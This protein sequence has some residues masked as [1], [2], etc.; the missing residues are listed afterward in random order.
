[1]SRA[2]RRPSRLRGRSYALGAQLDTFLVCAASGVIVNHAFLIVTGSPQI[3]SRNPGAVHISHSIYGG[4][5][6]MVAIVLTLAYLA[7]AVRWVLA[8]VGGVG[9]GWWVDELGK[10]VSNAGYLFEPALALIYVTFVVMYLAF[11]SLSIRELGPEDALVNALATAK[12]AAL[13]SLQDP[14]RREILA[15]FDAAAPSGPF[16][17][18]VR[19]LL[20]DAPASPPLPPGRVR[21][22]RQRIRARY[23]AWTR[24]R[25]FVIVIDAVFVA[26]AAAILGGVLGLSLDGPGI[27]ACSERV[28]SV[29][30]T[31]A[32]ILTVSGVVRLL[33]SRLAA[34]RWFER[35]VFVR[36]L[37]VQVYLFAQEQFTAVVGLGVDLVLWVMLR[38]AIRVEEEAGQE[39][40]HRAPAGAADEAG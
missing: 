40:A 38:S 34:D 26:I 17:D 21:R 33:R 18:R 2:G 28:A 4:F 14:E 6:M 31:V 13:G 27:S 9:F 23:Q 29:G 35:A 20:D 25:S 1:M 5:A 8:V 7:P 15:R 3:G 37:V 16:A 12:A 22:A 24:T 19:A 10:Y 36:I 30:A 11:R 39:R 32:G